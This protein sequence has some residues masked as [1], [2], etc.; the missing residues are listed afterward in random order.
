MGHNCNL[1]LLYIYHN[2]VAPLPD[3]YF[4]YK[5]ALRESGNSFYDT[6]YIALKYPEMSTSGTRLEDLVK[7]IRSTQKNIMDLS[8]DA[9]FSRYSL[10][11]QVLH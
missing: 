9:A 1:D 6:K 5:K 4:E 2:L 8:I 11:K 10:D 7:H 3:S